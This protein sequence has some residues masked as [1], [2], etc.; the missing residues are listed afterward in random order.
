M[1]ALESIIA[2]LPW[3]LAAGVVLSGIRLLFGVHRLPANE[4]PRSWRIALLLLGQGASAVL[5]FLL[6]R[7]MLPGDS[8]HTLHVLTAHAPDMALPAPRTGERWLWLPEATPR[9]GIAATPD[10]ATALRQHPHIR[11]LHIIGDGLQTHDRDAA[12]GLKIQFDA[13]P[14]ETGLRDWWASPSV[15]SGNAVHVRGVSNGGTRVELLDPAGVRVDQQTLQADGAFALQSASRSPGLAVYQLRL[16]DE[17]DKALATIPI[18][19]EVLASTASHLLLRSGGPDPELKFLRRWAADNGATLQA[20]IDLGA[21]M[22]AGDPA[23]ALD[24]RTLAETDVLILDDRSWNGLGRSSRAN[25]LDAVSKGLGLLLRT[26]MPLADGDALGMQVRAASL[27][28]S[29]KLPVVDADDAT[30]PALTRPQLRIDNPAGQTVLRDDHGNPLAAWR[31]HGRGRI[32][33]W[34]PTDSYRLALAGHADLHARLW[35]DAVNHVARGRTPVPR[36]MPARIYAGER[37]VV[38]DL[39]KTA[40]I[41]QPGDAT[42]VQLAIDPDSGNKH[43]AA[44]WPQHAGWHRLVEA[45]PA[46]GAHSDDALPTSN[47]S[48]AFLVRARDA[49][50]VMRAARTQHATAAFAEQTPALLKPAVVTATLTLP[51]WTLF[52]L[53][54]AVTSALWWFERSRFGRVRAAT[55]G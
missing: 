52:L 16:L 48:T 44:F 19:V 40:T 53:W 34:L 5:L 22:Q 24:T 45:E 3:L 11:N 36:A 17:K 50:Q 37:V 55:S 32:G 12:S 4:R 28:A 1:I 18:P 33:I 14:L 30:L 49:D 7:T 29:F 21:G 6:L 23:F 10:L 27:P 46:D 54:L 41:V 35:A 43:C 51:R 31:A 26:T 25:V 20:T 2:F 42:P 13:A 39:E 38:C 15:Q 8:I 47:S 9:E